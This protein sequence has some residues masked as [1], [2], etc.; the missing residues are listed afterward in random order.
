V[1]TKSEY[2]C[3][4]ITDIKTGRELN[5]FPYHTPGVGLS[6]FVRKEKEGVQ[7]TLDKRIHVGHMELFARVDFTESEIQQYINELI[8]HD[9]PILKEI[10]IS[11]YEFL[12]YVYDIDNPHLT[13]LNREGHTIEEEK[14]KPKL[15]LTINEDKEDGI[16]LRFCHDI[17]CHDTNNHDNDNIKIDSKMVFDINNERSRKLLGLDDTYCFLYDNNNSKFSPAIWKER[18]YIIVDHLL[19]EFIKICSFILCSVVMMMFFGR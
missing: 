10:E 13:I 14:G 8:N 17:I 4:S 16:S 11:D 5:F 9:D 15:R 3:C 1:S 6:D 7:S 19:R 18:R 2:G 12:S